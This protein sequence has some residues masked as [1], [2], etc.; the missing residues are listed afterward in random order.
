MRYAALTVALFVVTS[1]HLLGGAT[2]SPGVPVCSQHVDTVGDYPEGRISDAVDHACRR[3]LEHTDLTDDDLDALPDVTVR[4][5]GAGESTEHCQ[6]ARS[7]T[8]AARVP[9]GYHVD[10]RQQW[11]GRPSLTDDRITHEMMH[12]L[13]FEIGI[14]A[15]DHH[16]WMMRK[17]LCAEM[18]TYPNPL[19]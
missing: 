9:G 12:V 4:V 10:V 16:R 13:A 11:T 17:N 7:G 1:C 3:M 19:D 2:G 14:P 5:Y 18:C 8:C 15:S 6:H